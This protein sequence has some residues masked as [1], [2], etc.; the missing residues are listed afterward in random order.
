MVVL[1]DGLII[2]LVV[3]SVNLASSSVTGLRLRA[4]NDIVPI[5]VLPAARMAAKEDL[6][7][8]IQ[9]ATDD[10]VV[11][12]DASPLCVETWTVPISTADG[13]VVH[14]IVPLLGTGINRSLNLWYACKAKSTTVLAE[15]RDAIGY[16]IGSQTRLLDTWCE[17]QVVMRPSGTPLIIMCRGE[18]QLFSVLL[19]PIEPR[20][21]TL[22]LRCEPTTETVAV[23]CRDGD[24]ATARLL[25]TVSRLH[26]ERYIDGMATM[27]FAQSPLMLVSYPPLAPGHFHWMVSVVAGK[28]AFPLALPPVVFSRYPVP[29]LGFVV[30]KDDQWMLGDYQPE[31]GGKDLVAVLLGRPR[32]EQVVRIVRSGRYGGI[33][34]ITDDP[35]HAAECREALLPAARRQLDDELM[36][37]GDR[38]EIR[39]GTAVVDWDQ[40]A[41]V[42]AAVSRI[43][44]RLP[45]GGDLEV[46]WRHHWE[47]RLP[48]IPVPGDPQLAVACNVANII[49]GSFPTRLSN[50]ETDWPA[51]I[52]DDLWLV[53]WPPK[54]RDRSSLLA[55]IV[56]RTASE[57][58]ASAIFLE[59]SGL[60]GQVPRLGTSTSRDTDAEAIGHV[61][62]YLFRWEAYSAKQMA[63]HR[64]RFCEY[65]DRTAAD[66]RRIIAL[67]AQ[68]IYDIPPARRYSARLSF[69]NPLILVVASV[70]QYVTV[71]QID[72]DIAFWSLYAGRATR[73]KA[74]VAVATFPPARK[75]DAARAI[76][77]ALRREYHLELDDQRRER[78]C[79][80]R[81]ELGAVLEQTLDPA[82]SEVLER[83]S[84]DRVVAFSDVSLDLLPFGVGILGLEIPTCRLPG[85]APSMV[86]AGRAISSATSGQSETRGGSM[87][88]GAQAVILVADRVTDPLTAWSRAMAVE[89][90]RSLKWVGLVATIPDMAT[91]TVGERLT[92]AAAG[93]LIIFVGHAGTTG[94]SAVLHLGT[95]L[96][97]IEDVAAVDWSGS[98]VILVG[99]ET[100]AHDRDET[101][102]ALAFLTRGARA[103]VGTSAKV[104]LGVANYFV[105]EFMQL[106][107]AA[108]PIDYAFFAARRRAAVYET[109][110]TVMSSEGAAQRI[111]EAVSR[112]TEYTLRDFLEALG[113]TW[114][115]VERHAMFALTFS[116]LGGAG[117]CLV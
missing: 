6:S 29:Y 74:G 115:D 107:L 17:E 14:L 62:E 79:S 19:W 66:P 97:E 9:R 100:A 30:G 32:V 89:V 106:L 24:T 23:E 42:D 58:H 11:R 105:G 95:T 93:A 98:V 4:F 33:H 76:L 3:N 1:G 26:S 47:N 16:S 75:I 86:T 2:D 34:V 28:D 81:A 84:A 109:L 68:Y 35:S 10:F 91:G 36:I 20:E 90:A 103:V 114:S 88:R 53:P 67:F 12:P 111:D 37:I 65:I 99:C 43:I 22:T 101:D 38:H 110:R 50:S 78:I 82:A 55:G 49:R 7:A 117:E 27:S 96:V 51:L 83:L 59:L 48:A 64:A 71:G 112:G 69:A 44:T 13:S 108:V 116:L 52:R 18:S 57:L 25:F 102:V 21:V 92:E 31:G 15:V 61:E 60:S 56:C 40:S 70:E 63:D 104:A 41:S 72:L 80:L 94:E 39:F 77:G 85:S 45:A 46:M 8:A 113:L 54:A 73:R 87:T 5:A